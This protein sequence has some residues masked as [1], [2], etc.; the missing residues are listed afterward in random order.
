MKTRTLTKKLYNSL[1]GC[2]LILLLS[3]FN[4]SNPSDPFWKNL[5]YNWD[6]LHQSNN[7]TVSHSDKSIE[8]SNS[9]SN[10][11]ISNSETFSSGT[12]IIPMDN[13]KQSVSGDFNLKAYGLVVTLLHNNIPLKW[14]I[15]SS[16]AKDGIDFSASSQRVAP[17]SNTTQNRD[18]KAGPI[19]IWPGYESQATTVINNFGND[20]QVYELKESKSIEIA[21]D[22]THKPKG[23]VF[24]NGNK[25]SIHMEIYEDAGL[26]EGT[27]YDEVSSASTINGNSCYT[28]ASEPH[29]KP[30][31]IS[32]AIVSNVLTFVENGGNFLAQCEGVE[33]YAD[34][35][36]GSLLATFASKPDID[37]DIVFEYPSEPF[38]QIHGELKDQGGSVESFKFVTNPS[39]GKRVA[40]DSNDGNNYKAYVGMVPNVVANAG[41]Y[42]HYLAGHE[43]KDKDGNEAINGRR[44]FLNAFIRPADR[45]NSCGLVVCSTASN[46]TSTANILENETKTL[47]GTPAEGTWSIVSGGGTINGNTYTPANIAGNT[48]VTVRYTIAATG[49]C[50]ESTADVT[51]T[52]NSVPEATVS[53]TDVTCYGENDGTITFTFPD[54]YSRT[55]IQ[56]SLDG[57]NT[58]ESKVADNSESVTYSNL[59][60]GTYD[61]WARWGNTNYPLDLGTDIVITEPAQVIASNTTSTA[62][63]SENGT[64]ELTGSPSGGTWS[65]V[66][67]GG[68]I[69]GTTYTPAD[70]NTD[71]DVTIRYTVPKNGNCGNSTSDVTFTVSSCITVTNTTST[72]SISET[73]TKTLSASPASPPTATI[74]VDV[75]NISLGQTPQPARVIE[76]EEVLRITG[77]GY[78]NGTITV[79]SGGHVVVCGNVTIYG[80]VVVDNGGHYWKTSTTG[81]I[82]SIN[83]N[84]TTHEGPT[85][86]SSGTWSIVS[87][88]GTINGTTYTPAD[89]NTDTDVTIRYTVAAD[90]SCSET[91]ADV[92]FTVTPVCVTAV[93]S[94]ATASITEDETK[95]LSGSPSGGTWSIVSGGGSISGTTYTP[96]DINTNTDVTIRYTIAA[97]G[98][99]AESTADVT[100]TVTPVCVTAVNSTATA[101]ITEDET[102]TLSGSPSGGTWSIVSGGGTINGT[103]Y[104]PADINT[105]TDVTIRYTI[106]ADGSCSE[107]YADVTFTVTAAL[108]GSIGDRVWFDT[109]GDTNQDVG[110]PGLEGATVTL[111]PG[112]PG[113]T[114]DDV[115]TTT[116]A[117]GLYLFENLP[118]GEYTITVDVSTVTDGIPAGKTVA[119]LVQNF[120]YDG[121]GTANK[122][123]YNLGSGEHNREQDF[124]YVV[125]TDPP[126]C[127]GNCGGVESESL[128]DAITKVYVGRK[129]NSV[130]TEFVKDKSN[131]YD[132]KKLQGLQVYQGKGQ[133]MLDMFPEE[134][135]PGDVSHVTSPTDILDYTIAD[136][137]LSVD[138]SLN[139]QTQGVVLGIKTTDRVYNHTKASCDRLRGA[140]VLNVQ[141]IH[142]HGHDF[143]MQALQQRNG[144]V[145]YAISFAI[146][147]NNNDNFYDL[148]TSWYVNHYNKF[149]DMYNFQ[150]WSTNP[151]YTKKLLV[152]IINNLNSY[153]P[154]KQESYP[155]TP[156]T[157]ASKIYR[158]K[159][160]L[161]IKL[162]STVT[163]KNA[164][165]EMV[166][167]YS[168]TANNIKH[169]FNT[170]TTTK[171][172]E[173]RVDIADGYEYDGLIKIDGNI[174]DAFYHADGNWGLDFDKR[175]TEIKNYFVWNDFNRT[176]RDDELPINR[177]VELKATS[178]YDYLMLY[179]SL[180]PGNISADYN[181]YSYLAFTAKGAGMIEL[182]LLKASIQDWKEQ[183]RVMVE[184]SEEEQTYYVPFEIFTSMASQE[185]INAD[186][187]TTIIF[188]WLPTDSNS[189]ELDLEVSDVRFVKKASDDG[190]LVE[191]IITYDNQYL[192]Y[193]NPSEGHL[194]TL[195][196]S[197]KAVEATVTLHDITGKIVYR[198]QIRLQEGKNE[199]DLNFNVSPGIMLLNIATNE[200]DFGTTKIIFR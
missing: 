120:D 51:F 117:D 8:Y 71:T 38:I 118:A 139:G 199:I 103:T 92:T 185:K 124:G 94:T 72:A 125:T 30:N 152:D 147:K 192:A 33:A 58:Y 73:E 100:F 178:D 133:T 20:V 74:Q 193:P 21:H 142:L 84:G 60:P 35:S 43:Y 78:Y 109:D 15:N 19:I 170:V 46:T 97:D 28:F 62:T 48:N 151:T 157:F 182:G 52:I 106:A 85:S 134:L 65:I 137:V 108:L 87:G 177:N 96:A 190:V 98:S 121:L 53:K 83:V 26:T 114:T 63:I 197:D 13:D 59:S 37:G 76:S 194:T 68:S 141:T 88:G 82:G 95:T 113:N 93:N 12:L 162:R 77:N 128:G 69:S 64:K 156:M 119:D 154:V 22:L 36:N 127:G 149:N 104:T 6:S 75:D 81:F 180:L 61:V 160:D 181:E 164:D 186:D 200:H 143:L 163:G 126:N 18:F 158:D 188:N 112:T 23:A 131:R 7:S 86:C 14:A 102:K 70:I 105:D 146:G 153:I 11:L 39:G 165:I 173:I 3:S 136:E 138:F 115:N 159:S 101:S 27:H 90:G 1:F 145:E 172:Q 150:V 9:F 191:P 111:D 50:A 32:S 40:Y 198:S 91:S 4:E 155:A 110:E 17:T 80:S 140:E 166:E 122:S 42:V 67:G 31:D 135:V 116:G 171:E 49:S 56:F 24:D 183:Y 129:K 55:H 132:K 189:T 168:E 45:P 2:V 179:K 99:C 176:Y 41:G 107:T 34:N 16:K 25:S 123:T 144:S 89:I 29:T 10:T 148:Q 187:L 174:Q 44:M 79:R 54:N 47:V 66:S 130:P 169:R 184:F 195:L 175:Y 57:G 196:F 167:L 161:V 5:G